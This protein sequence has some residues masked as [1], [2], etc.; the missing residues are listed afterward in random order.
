MR[1]ASPGKIIYDPFV[2][3]GSMLYVGANYSDLYAISERHQDQCTFWSSSLW[4]R[5]RWSTDARKTFV[6]SFILQLRRT[7]GKNT[8]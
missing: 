2:G 8:G 7:I 3:T 5:H 1:K 6:T 4:L